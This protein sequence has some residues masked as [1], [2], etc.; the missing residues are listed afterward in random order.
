MG[1]LD[2]LNEELS[3]A[4]EH[5]DKAKEAKQDYL[6]RTVCSKKGC[7]DEEIMI[8]CWECKRCG[9]RLWTL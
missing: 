5:L 3:V 4:Y 1:K 9:H 2:K 6:K 7:D 8:G